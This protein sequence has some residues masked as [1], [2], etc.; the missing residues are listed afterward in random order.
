VGR[1]GIQV[2]EDEVNLV[3]VAPILGERR[4]CLPVRRDGVVGNL[5]VLRIIA[6]GMS[7]SFL[8][9]FVIGGVSPTISAPVVLGYIAG[10]DC[11]L[12]ADNS[13]SL[14]KV[15]AAHVSKR[16]ICA[17]V[18]RDGHGDEVSLADGALVEPRLIVSATFQAHA[19]RTQA[20]LTDR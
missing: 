2:E 10:H 6:Y 15:A 13:T 19:L 14:T 16:R 17:L 1:A 20:K 18:L 8:S 7:V 4:A 3:R 11:L 5:G 12:A 9:L